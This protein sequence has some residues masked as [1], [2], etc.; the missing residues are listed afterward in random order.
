VQQ[1]QQQQLHTGLKSW[2]QQLRGAVSERNGA[3][4]AQLVEE[5]KANVLPA[6]S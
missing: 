5:L 4:V 2:Y 1:Q 6:A 3:M